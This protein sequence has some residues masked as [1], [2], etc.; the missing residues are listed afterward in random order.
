VPSKGYGECPIDTARARLERARRRHAHRFGVSLSDV[1][2]RL[3]PN[4]FHGLHKDGRELIRGWIARANEAQ[5]NNKFEAFI[6]AWIGFNGWASCCCEAEADRVLLDLMILDGGLAENFNRLTVG[7]PNSQAAENFARLWP[8]FKVTDLPDLPEHARRN[9]PQHRGR[10]AVVRYYGEHWP[11]A[12]RA[13]NCHLK[14]DATI[15]TDWGHTLEALYRVRNNLF[16]G[17]K[18][19]AGREDK[20]IV[21]AAVDI[22]LPVANSVLARSGGHAG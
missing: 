22:L 1:E 21:D 2:W 13:P 12:D 7:G 9:R 15:K 14:H 5:S 18:S 19:G 16:H 11:T 6:Y 17:Q 8:I 4:R 3:D 10:A 20:E